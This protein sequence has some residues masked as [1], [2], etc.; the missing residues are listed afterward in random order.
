MYENEQSGGKSLN[1]AVR[2]ARLAL[3]VRI[4]FKVIFSFGM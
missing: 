3:P 4:K 2:D 1:T